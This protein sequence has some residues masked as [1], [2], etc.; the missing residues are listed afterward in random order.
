MRELGFLAS[1]YARFISG[2]T[3][4]DGTNWRCRPL[5]N[6]RVITGRDEICRRSL[7]PAPKSETALTS[8]RR[9]TKE[10]RRLFMVRHWSADVGTQ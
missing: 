4:L 2:H 10:F 5:T 1:P 8:C 9:D 7:N 3:V 6:L